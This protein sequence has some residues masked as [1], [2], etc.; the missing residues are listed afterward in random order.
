MTIAEKY[1][2][3]SE[4]QIRENL[5]HLKKLYA[6]WNSQINVISR[7]DFDNF[8]V[9]HLLHSLSIAKVI[10]FAKGTKIL[11][12]GT[13]GGFPGIPL[14]IMLPNVEFLLVD[15]N[16]KKIKVVREVA[17]ELGLKNVEAF[18]GRAEDV[19]RKFDFIVSR[20]VTTLP[21]F[22]GWVQGKISDQTKNSVPNGILYLKGGDITE[23]LAET[24]MQHNIYELSDYFEESF[25]E[26]KKIVHLFG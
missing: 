17:A 12:V 5:F 13:G 14:A 18:N 15:S 23:E 8:E 25:F 10:Q 1:F 9:H 19:N 3:I 26:T 16:G 7:K 6:N 22:V 11:D 2:E 21:K 20:A 24:K 4:R